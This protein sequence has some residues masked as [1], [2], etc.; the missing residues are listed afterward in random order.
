MDLVD[1]VPDYPFLNYERQEIDPRLDEAREE[2][3]LIRVRLPYFDQAWLAT[4][5]DHVR[6][7]LTD[8]RL[9]RSA[10]PGPE[11]P[12]QIPAPSCVQT[13][14]EVDPSAFDRCRRAFTRT[15]SPRRIDEF[16]PWIRATVHQLIDDMLAAGPPADLIRAVG[17][18]LPMAVLCRILGVPADDRAR[19]GRW[20]LALVGL[21]TVPDVELRDAVDGLK[22]YLRGLIRHRRDEPADDVFSVLVSARE[23][24]GDLTDDDLIG[25]GVTLLSA[26]F[27]TTANHLAGSAFL[28]LS[29]G[30]WSGLA[31]QP[32]RL[33]R[34]V[35]ELLRFV[36]LNSGTGLPRVAVQD[37]ELG[38]VTIR[39][40]EAV[41]VSTVAANRD[42]TVFV[43][44]DDF[45]PDR[46]PAMPHLAFGW[47][48]HRCLGARLATVQLEET[49]AGL[50][51]RVPA[52]RLAVPAR[53]VRWRTGTVLRSPRAL[54]VTW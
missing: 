13:I 6:Q 37:V 39:A 41:V 23:P 18:P 43:D 15:F 42:G 22:A 36:P 21:R 14:M 29:R 30:Y 50:R 3:S 54:P 45:D 49:L 28:L 8:P 11:V 26:G 46:V 24:D 9:R 20:T 48:P 7:V 10:A 52:L 53:S 16:R 4:R 44:A 31:A 17:M 5:Y 12:R 51:Q 47:G 2:G 38:G 19:F 33:T 25:F 1:Q 40:G 34:T 32:E 27:E 35:Q